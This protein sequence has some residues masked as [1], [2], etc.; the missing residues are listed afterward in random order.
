[1]PD[2]SS[3]TGGARRWDWR[4]KYRV[5]QAN[6]KPFAYPENYLEPEPDSSEPAE[7]TWS[8]TPKRTSDDATGC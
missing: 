2:R 5:W 7:R 4:S 3:D 8:A 6:R 1:M